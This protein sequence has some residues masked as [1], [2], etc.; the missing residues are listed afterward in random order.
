MCQLTPKLIY[1]Y[2]NKVFCTF[3]PNQFIL[4]MNTTGILWYRGIFVV[5][6]PVRR[7]WCYS[8]ITFIILQYI[9]C[10]VVDVNAA[11]KRELAA[12][13]GEVSERPW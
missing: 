10:R 9:F 3:L 7:L 5:H 13:T 12:R 6:I 1:I 2:E 8:T 4:K 11:R